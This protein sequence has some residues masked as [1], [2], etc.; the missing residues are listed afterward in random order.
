MAVDIFL[1]VDGIEGEATDVNHKDEIEVV[2]WS[3]GVE[4]PAAP[5]PGSGGASGRARIGDLAVVK[6]VDKASPHLFRRC[7]KGTHI[8]TVALAQRKSGAGN[9]HFLTITLN[10]V[11]VTRMN[12]ASDGGRPTESVSFSF[13]KVTYTYVPLKPNGQPDTPVTLRWNVKTNQEF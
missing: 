1:K 4:Q 12:D 7:V 8:P 10:E 3:L 11:L 2:S 13:G 6:Y 5:P 9:V